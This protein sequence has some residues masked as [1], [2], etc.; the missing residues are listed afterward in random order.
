MPKRHTQPAHWRRRARL[1]STGTRNSRSHRRPRRHRNR[2][3]VA[4]RRTARLDPAPARSIL[5]DYLLNL[6]EYEIASV[7]VLSQ[8]LDLLED[9]QTLRAQTRWPKNGSRALRPLPAEIRNKQKVLRAA[10]HFLL[11]MT[12]RLEAE[13]QKLEALVTTLKSQRVP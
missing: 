13:H 10:R 2:S 3:R 11:A 6:S 4:H 1:L 5:A 7:Q 8:R 9:L 12:G